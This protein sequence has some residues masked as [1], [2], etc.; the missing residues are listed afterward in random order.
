M[1]SKDKPYMVVDTHAGAGQYSLDAEHAKQT[2]EFTE[3][4][5]RLWVRKDLPEP[6]SAYLASIRELNHGEKLRRYPGSPWLISH[7][8]REKDRLR[9]CELH[10]TDAALLRREFKGM[11]P[12]VL[13]EQADG[14][15]NLKAALPPPSRRGLVLIDPSYEIKNDYARVVTA[16]KDALKR[17]STGTLIV[18]HPCIASLDAT[19]LPERLK[20]AGAAHWIHARLN[21]RAPVPMGRGMHGSGVFVINPPWRLLADLQR[22]L[23]FLAEVLAMD[24][25][26]SWLVDSFEQPS[27]AKA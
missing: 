23:P 4:I 13:I 24:D 10:S 12:R 3:G 11:A 19:Q 22:V 20:K 21:V 8:A 1:N 2:G 17:F 5:G 26:A 25:H 7:L 14:F 16:V 6:L 18:W 9:F 15:E 27:S